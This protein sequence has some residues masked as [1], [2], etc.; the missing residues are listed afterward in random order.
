M[1][2]P[3]F[4]ASVARETTMKTIGK[5]ARTKA[6]PGFAIEIRDDADLGNT[7]LIAEMEGGCYQWVG[8][9]VSIN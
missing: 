6:T 3:A 8:A 1:I 9:V 2:G 7:I 4:S 5:Q